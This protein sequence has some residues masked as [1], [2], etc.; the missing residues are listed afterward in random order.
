MKRPKIKSFDSF[1]EL[2]EHIEKEL[3]PCDGDCENCEYG[4]ENE[5][6][7]EA[8]EIAHSVRI[9]Y[10]AFIAEGFTSEEAKEFTKLIIA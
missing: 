7:L 9:L 6:E 3:N 4:T 10:E 2:F 8:A 5:M 1:E